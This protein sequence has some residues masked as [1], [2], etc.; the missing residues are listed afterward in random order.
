MIVQPSSRLGAVWN[1]R[2]VEISSGGCLV[3][4]ANPTFQ[5]GDRI[6]IAIAHVDALP[7]SVVSTS[8]QLIGVAFE[9]SLHMS[10]AAHIAEI[11]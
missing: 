2:A 9:R 8:P 1:A 4:G 7:A 3:T 5:V 6:R 11:R 10:V